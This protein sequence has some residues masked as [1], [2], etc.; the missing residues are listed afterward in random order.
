MD[1][2][3]DIISSKSAV[4]LTLLKTWKWHNVI[5]NVVDFYSIVGT[6]CVRIK[7]NQSHKHRKIVYTGKIAACEFHVEFVTWDQAVEMKFTWKYSCGI[8]MIFTWK[9]CSRENNKLIFCKIVS[10][11]KQRMMIFF[12]LS[13][14]PCVLK[15]R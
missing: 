6:V 15:I 8:H 5:Y 12:N 14:V 11:E 1:L 7:Y 2:I 4:M 3:K 10:V 13:D 9:F